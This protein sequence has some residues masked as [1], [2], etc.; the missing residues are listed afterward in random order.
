[1]PNRSQWLPA[2]LILVLSGCNIKSAAP[3]PPEMF[4]IPSSYPVG[5]NP[6]EIAAADVNNDGN[7][8]L[9]TANFGS[10]DLSVLLGNPDGTFQAHVR[11]A[12]A[13]Q[14]RLFVA[15]RFDADPYVDIAVIHH[16]EPILMILAGDGKGSFHEIQREDLKRT[17]T[18]IAAADF[19]HDG[20]LD[21]AVSLMMDRV[22]ILSGDGRGRFA[23][24]HT[25]DPG[26]TPTSILPVHLNGD[27]HWDLLIANDGLM[28]PGIAVFRGKGDGTFEKLQDYKTRL[29][30][31]ILSTGDYN[32]DGNTDLVVI[33]NSQSTLALFLG[34]GDGTLADGINFGSEG[35]PTSALWGD[36]NQDGKPDVL[37]TNNLNNKFSIHFGKGDGTFAY[38]P[39]T[40][41]AGQGP[42]S[43]V[44]G[45]FS[46]DGVEA[47]AIANNVG[48]TV[49]IFLAKKH[50]SAGKQ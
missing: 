24:T 33:Y 3:P 37:I 21:L 44:Y 50:P 31:L 6:T 13:V 4:N 7:P 18:S 28:A 12:V 41:P 27:G 30:P 49:S 35:G 40:Y 23:V 43:T 10:N 22:L 20:K 45:K 9:I 46:R 17:A 42:F 32:L 29:R 48:N 39:A 16:F 47:L 5:V 15:G 19:N 38:P 26:D 11:S 8:D 1:M 14:P 34:R 36:Y 2:V 25:F